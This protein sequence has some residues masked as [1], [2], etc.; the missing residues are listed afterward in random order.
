MYCTTTKDFDTYT[1]TKLFYEPG[2]NVIDSTIV[3]DGDRCVMIL[4][5]ETRHP[6]AKNLRI[7]SSEKVTGPW[8]AASKSF[9]PD[10]LWVEGPSCLKVGEYWYV[11]FDA[12]AKHRYGAMRTA[13]F[14]NWEDVSD[15]LSFPKG[16]RHG[17]VFAVSQEVLDKLLVA[18]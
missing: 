5:D 1:K 6:P 7:A 12:Y 11:Y 13:D 3:C 4:K 9:T 15:Q 14:Q 16:T 8:S 2:F 17:T 18:E 10:G